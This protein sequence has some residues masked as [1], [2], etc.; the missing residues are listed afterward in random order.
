MK[1]TKNQQISLAE[2]DF[3]VDLTLRGFPVDLLEQFAIQIAEP[4]Y[5]G[6][7]KE[8]IKDLMLHAVAEQELVQNHIRRE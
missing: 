8:A 2:C 3:P 4:Y 6:S 5:R 1:P 7:L